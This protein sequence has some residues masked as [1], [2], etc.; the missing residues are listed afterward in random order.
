MRQLSERA[1]QCWWQPG[2]PGFAI[3]P[4]DSERF[5]ASLQG[6]PGP[7]AV[8]LGSPLLATGAHSSDCSICRDVL[9]WWPSWRAGAQRR[10]L[11]WVHAAALPESEGV[12]QRPLFAALQQLNPT[13]LDFPAIQRFTANPCAVEPALRLCDPSCCSGGNCGRGGVAADAEHRA[14]AAAVAAAVSRQHAAHLAARRRP[15]RRLLRLSSAI[16]SSAWPAL[17]QQ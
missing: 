15:Q 13:V 14:V 3:A 10:C 5:L 4:L 1:A 12:M 9:L 6:T 2:H 16:S 7:F 17:T 11:P 8:P